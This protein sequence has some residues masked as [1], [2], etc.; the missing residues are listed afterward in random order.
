MTV[1]EHN[2]TFLTWYQLAIQVA[3]DATVVLMQTVYGDTSFL[4]FLG[5]RAA[6]HVSSFQ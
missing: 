2:I 6:H 4:A 3:H 1:I 5:R